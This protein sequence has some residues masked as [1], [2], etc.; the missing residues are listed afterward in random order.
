MSNRVSIKEKIGYG[1]G[2]AAANIGWRGVGTFLFIFYTDVF[3][4]DPVTVGVL[5]L[6]ARLS[7]GI[8]D[9][10]MGVIGD[11]TKSKYGK[12]RPWIL[13]TAIPLAISLILLFSSP[14]FSVSGKIIY[15]Y[16]TYL[17]F[18]LMYTAN[19]VPYGALM[20]VM[21]GDDK[22]RTSIGAYRMVGAFGGGI[23][24]QGALLFLIAYFGNVD[25]SIKVSNL[26]NNTYQV[27]IAATRDVENT[28]IKT[29]DGIATFKWNDDRNLEYAYC[30]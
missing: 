2:D 12:F 4:L 26:E 18:T 21:T 30:R 20:A 27:D 15:A 14:E 16:I 6:T 3:G 24:V 13:W 1:L 23:L 25:P 22:E 7:D 9:V 28:N 17:F 29:E 8:S 10:V 19:N 5:F 11:R